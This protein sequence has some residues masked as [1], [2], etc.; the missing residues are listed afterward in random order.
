MEVLKIR[1]LAGL[2][3]A[4]MAFPAAAQV[5]VSTV[6]DLTVLASESKGKGVPILLMFSAP[7]CGYC[8]RLERDYLKPMI[9]SGDYDDK[10]I[11]RKV[12]I[13]AR[14]EVVGFDGNREAV[15]ALAERYDVFV[16]PTVV[17]IGPDGNPLAEKLV[18][19]SSPDFYGSYLDAA[20]DTSLKRFRAMAVA[21]NP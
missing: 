19:Y 5:N 13:G 4:L 16:T 11:I 18:G 14:A 21:A 12:Q 15:E 3:A 2:L 7:D 8:T 9:T 17:F 1:V 10:I 20:I 6:K